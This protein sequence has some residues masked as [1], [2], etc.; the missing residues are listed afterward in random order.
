MNK[1]LLAE[2]QLQNAIYCRCSLW[3]SLIR[4]QSLIKL[5][6]VLRCKPNE[7]E[8]ITDLK[9][10]LYVCQFFKA[11]TPMF[12]ATMGIWQGSHLLILF[13]SGGNDFR[14]M[15]H[16]EMNIAHKLTYDH[17]IIKYAKPSLLK[18][19]GLQRV[20]NRSFIDTH[21]HTVDC[22]WTQQLY[23]KWFSALWK[24]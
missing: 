7:K 10:S 15:R 14:F 18:H 17:G 22:K 13:V 5:N 24:S 1:S 20:E 12:T 21:S 11:L 16:I 2:T 8:K 6:C 3:C 4:E 23:L 9:V 19:V